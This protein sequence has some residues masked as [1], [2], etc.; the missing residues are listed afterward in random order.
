MLNS[1]DRME[2]IIEYISAYESKIKMANKNGLFD[3]AKMFELFAIE[4]CNL[5]FNQEFHNLNDETANYP[6]LDLVSKDLEI[7]VQVS[8]V[9]NIPPKIKS[10]LEKIRDSKED[11]FRDIKTVTFFMLSNESIESVIDY[12]EEKKIGNISFSQ[13][14][15]LITTDD[16]VK[17]AETEVDFQIKLYNLLLNEFESFNNHVK[18][19]NEAL[20]MSR[21]VGL[22]NIDVT[23]N[24]EYEIDR[25]SILNKIKSANSQFVSIQGSAGSGKSALC[26]KYVENETYVLYARAE[27]FLEAKNIN[28]IWS[29]NIID[30]L[31]YLNGKKIVFIIDALEFIADSNDTKFE[32]LQYMYEVASNFEN[33]YIL[34]SCRTSDSNAFIRLSSFY[35]IDT[36]EVMDLSVD[37]LLPIMVKYP[38]I[39]KMQGMKS[40]SDLL[41]SPFYINLVVSNDISIDDIEDENEFRD[42]IWENIICLKEKSILYGLSYDDVLESVKKIVFKRAKEYLLGIHSDEVNNSVLHALISENVI[43]MQGKY[44]R[45][46]YDIFEDICFENYLDK[47]FLSCKGKYHD[48]YKEIEK[49]GRC[50]YRRYQI[51]ISNKLFIHENREKFIY[52]LIFTDGLPSEWK[53]QTEIGIVKSRFCNGF[54]EEYSTEILRNDLVLEFVK[55]VNLFAFD[56]KL[57]NVS[58]ILPSLRLSPMGDGRPSLIR[59]IANNNIFKSKEILRNHIIKICSDYSRQEVSD[60]SATS[61]CRIMQYYIEQ[62]MKELDKTHYYNIAEEIAPCLEV[63]YRIPEYAN[64][65][66]KDFWINLR[67]D[68]GSDESNK[69]R[70]AENVIEWSLKNAYPAL[71]STHA[72]GLCLLADTFWLKKNQKKKHE[73]IY[74]FHRESNVLLYGLSK[75]AEHHHFEYR[76][77]KENVFLYNL[78]HV[79]FKTGLEWAIQ[80][81]NTVFDEYVLNEPRDLV[82][83]QIYFDKTKEVKEYWGNPRVWLAGTRD[84]NVPTLIGDVLYLLNEIL[85]NT[86]EA[87]KNDQAYTLLFA[88]HIKEQIY[89]KSNNIA[90]LTIIEKIGLHFENAMPGYALELATSIALL[91]WDIARWS[92]YNPNPTRQL[93]EKQ[94]LMAVGLPN[95]EDRYILDQMCN[96]SLQD[97]FSRLQIYFDTTLR[98]KCH[99][100]LDYLY[101]RIKNDEEHSHEFLQIQKMD[102]RNAVIHTIDENTISLEPQITGEAKKVVENH[103]KSQEKYNKLVKLLEESNKTAV[104]GQPELNSM[105]KVIDFLLEIMDGS[106]LDFQYEDLFIKLIAFALLSEELDDERRDFYCRKWIKGI[107]RYFEN[108]SFVADTETFP[109]LIKQLEGNASLDCK[110]EIKQLIFDC[111]IYKGEQ[112]I[113]RNLSKYIKEY[114]RNNKALA[115]SVFNT[116]IVLA[117]D[118]MNHQKYNAKYLK[119]YRKN[120]DFEFIPNMQPK[121]KG[122]DYYIKDD[123]IKKVYS[124]NKIEIINR[125]LLLNEELNLDIFDFNNYDLVTISNIANCGLSFEDDIFS[126]VMHEILL[127]LIDTWKFKKDNNGNHVIDTFQEYEIV[128]LYQRKMVQSDSE[129]KDVIDSLF[130][131]IDFAKFTND[132]IE[133]Y[134]DIFGNFLPEFFDSHSN[135]TRRDLCKTKINYIEY[136]VLMIESEF[137]RTQLFK[138]LMLSVTR[139]S[140]VD[141]SK[142][143]TK[144][145]FVDKQFLNEQ[146][147]KFG[148]FHIKELLETIYQMHIDELLP[149]IVISVAASFRIAN[150]DKRNFKKIIDAQKNLVLIIILKAFTSYSDVIKQDQELTISYEEILEILIDLNYEEAAVLLDEFRVH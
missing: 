27:R 103:E 79:D 148:S 121:L 4:I 24:G 97:Y 8:T 32:L 23:I 114:L 5:W 82:K 45:L 138:A 95:L 64:V 72:N 69:R 67:K 105:I 52:Y 1:N 112:G 130:E 81:V 10:T 147:T 131:G 144:Y 115:T 63:L 128:E 84:H 62:T 89:T 120:N 94:I 91:E 136:K 80:F 76:S 74:S 54:F 96:L 33:V 125:Y 124:S 102:I 50:V 58:S 40:Y 61:A 108:G 137:V 106:D 21:N 77:V 87:Y 42:Y 78:F 150:E 99:T 47:Q 149:E 39:K 85:I 88:N 53:R 29:I 65:W 11:K 16:I 37:E 36:Y 139:C 129:S 141:W 66:I 90:M 86:I 46:K 143:V 142:I 107:R 119:K 38:L 6:Y 13:K 34:N 75:N 140:R 134:Q 43:S 18:S 17:K 31:R 57:S 146:F 25:S 145:S 59:I 123:G 55:I 26:K 20:E 14:D 70:I 101:E 113:V 28:D 93:L 12:N 71:V 126:K 92:L 116:I 48:F 83:V 51:W 15:N 73:E 111:L 68:Y 30:V 132:T 104:N 109:I 60:D 117:E 49:L 3:S 56:V 2:F 110:N 100:V 122:V 9:K 118:E 19:F 35:S 41:K 44:I 135:R 98:D 22:K 133:F 127:C 7:M